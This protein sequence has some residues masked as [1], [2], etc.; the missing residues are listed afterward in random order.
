MRAIT[1]NRGDEGLKPYASIE[2]N[3][4][5]RRYAEP[6]PG[7]RGEYERDRD[8]IVHCTAFRRLVYKTQVF[9]NHEGDLYRTRLTHSLEVAQIARTIAGALGLNGLTGVVGRRA[10]GVAAGGAGQ[11]AGAGESNGHGRRPVA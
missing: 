11:V 2:A 9:V 4:R 3:M 8:R 5:G 10:H 1:E 7:Y 6:G